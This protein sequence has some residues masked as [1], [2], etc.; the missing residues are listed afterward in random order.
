VDEIMELEV[1]LS[2]FLLLLGE[3]SYVEGLVLLANDG[4]TLE[5]VLH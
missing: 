1:I 2:D 5:R 3:A 4:Q